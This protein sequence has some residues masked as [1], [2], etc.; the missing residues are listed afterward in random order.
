MNLAY[1]YQRQGLWDKSLEVSDPEG[2]WIKELGPMI[3]ERTQALARYRAV[4]NH[5]F[6]GRWPEAVVLLDRLESSALPPS[7]EDWV[8]LRRGNTLDAQG[9]TADAASYYNLIKN[10][11]AR[12]LADI[13]L[14][15]PFPDGPRDVMPNHWPLPNIP[16][17]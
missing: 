13:F 6:A 2:P 15:T 5:L 9:R 4:E 3:K 1:V 17:Q 8:A 11:K 12:G 16:L 10:R 14:K 7:M